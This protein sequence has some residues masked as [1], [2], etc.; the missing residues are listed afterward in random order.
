[1][2]FLIKTVFSVGLVAL[3]TNC[4]GGGGSSS[5]GNNSG[6]NPA[7][8]TVTATPSTA[9]TTPFSLIGMTV[10]VAGANGTAVTDGTSVRLQ[11]S[12]PGVGLVSAAD[13]QTIVLA[14]SV[15]STT[16]GGIANFR[17]H[18]R[19]IGTA[20][21]IASVTDS[22]APARSVSSTATV[23]VI[24][25]VAND[26]RITLQIQT[27]TIPTIPA[28]LGINLGTV[29]PGSPYVSEVT[30]IQRRLDGTL[31]NGGS[32]TGGGAG[33]DAACSSG[34]GAAAA[35]GSGLNSSALWLP[36]EGIVEENGIRVI[37]LCRSLTLGINSGRT[38]FYVIGTGPQGTSQLSVTATDPQTGETL[39]ASQEFRI[40]NGAPQLPGSVVIDAGNEPVYITSVNGAR[41]K[42]IEVGVY[43]GGGDLVPAP[44]VVGANN[45]RLEIQ[46]GG[47]GGERLR[48]VNGAGTTVQGDSISLRTANGIAN[49]TFEAGTRTG[50]VTL[51]A[52]SD[53]ADNNIDNGIQDAV[54]STRQFTVSDGQ[55]FDLQIATAALADP[56]S[57]QV[58]GPAAGNTDPNA[59]YR[60]LITVL[61]VDRFGNPVP[62]G[63]EIRFGLIDEPQ[64]SGNFLIAGSDGDP[65]ENGTTFTALGGAFTTAGGG[66]GPND[67]LVVFA[68]EGTPGNRDGNRDMEAARTVTSVVSPTQLTVAL[69]FN[70]NDVTGTSVNAGPVFPYVVGRAAD[71]NIV[72]TGTTN[73]SGVARTVLNYPARRLGKR[74]IV[75][76]QG[77]GTPVNGRP[78]LVTDVE[79]FTF[80]GAGAATI[81]V[82][83][84]AI[85]ANRASAVR[86]CLRD[87]SGNGVPNAAFTFNF[88]IPTGSGTVDGRTAPGLTNTTGTDG[89]VSAQVNTL[90]VVGSAAAKV[91]F[92]SSGASADVAIVAGSGATLT[93]TPNP[94]V[95]PPGEGGS[96]VFLC[97]IDGNGPVAGVRVLDGGCVGGSPGYARIAGAITPTNT[98][99]CT[100]AA[101]AHDGLS[102]VV[103]GVV[104]IRESVCTFRTTSGLSTTLT[105]RGSNSCG[106][107]SPPPPGCSP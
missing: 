17:F 46:G 86:V 26:P 65:Q 76:A 52:T 33:G 43:D 42:Q 92:S 85:P 18:S 21:I 99:G 66:V 20:T 73:A 78:R 95:V 104:E 40:S 62:P 93:V 15:S 13:G 105:V 37:K 7:G 64:A 39:H 29:F 80:A 32:A 67:T 55:L 72:A 87:L 71:G 90:G 24:A 50:P 89:C 83:P 54:V 3:L 79:R 14:E 97:V 102:A 56:V 12:P 30:L 101:V 75:W 103:L 4:G 19:N 23:Q 68:E 51:I 49:A 9:S 61:G 94:L 70:P 34:S 47:Q 8:L 6:F 106:G 44:S 25:G 41:S 53:R 63:S 91:T 16:V 107:F 38:V 5:P 2:R 1:M 77:N 27:T 96:T 57:P 84:S 48:G 31:V 81:T 98:D 36:A 60:M 69:P 74:I 45:L 22:A 28:R 82:Q 100:S 88:S 10:R 59:I 35:L 58:T 11:V